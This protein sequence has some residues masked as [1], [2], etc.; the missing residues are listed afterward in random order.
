MLVARGLFIQQGE[1]DRRLHDYC[2]PLAPAFIDAL[3]L[4]FPHVARGLV[5]WG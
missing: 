3:P 2:D 1:T 4:T 5:A